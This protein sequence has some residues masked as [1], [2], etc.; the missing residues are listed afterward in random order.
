MITVGRRPPL[1]DDKLKV[2]IFVDPIDTKSLPQRSPKHAWC[3]ETF[4]THQ[5]GRNLDHRDPITDP[6]LRGPFHIEQCVWAEVAARKPRSARGVWFMGGWCRGT[7]EGVKPGCFGSI[8]ADG[9]IR[10]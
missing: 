10:G 3:V 4:P 6:E 9:S 2:P 1:S 7:A 8:A 5:D